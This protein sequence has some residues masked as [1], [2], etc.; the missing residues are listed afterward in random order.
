MES[1]LE[2]SVKKLLEDESV[3]RLVQSRLEEFK[4][5]GEEG[6]C[7]DIFSELSFC[8]LTANFSAERSIYIQRVLGRGFL[9]LSY[10]QLTKTL[11]ELGHRFPEKRAEFIVR[12][13]PLLNEIC[14][15]VKLK[16]SGKAKRNWLVE[17]VNGIGLKEASHFLRNVG[18]S[19]VAI[20]D[21]HILDLLDRYRIYERPKTL[22]K[23]KYLEI[24]TILEGIASRMKIGLD[25]LDLYLW[26]LETG[27][28]LK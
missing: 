24:E 25:A 14:K 19:D 17:R 9:T 18:F 8:I 4:K 23:K 5:L 1:S 7:E 27:K 21:F 28:V 2:E 12:N 6:S 15:L 16:G 10:S 11:R 26:Y 20:I 3:K 13:R 22:T